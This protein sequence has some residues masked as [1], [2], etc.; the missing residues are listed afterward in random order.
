MMVL[1]REKLVKLD[2]L[3]CEECEEELEFSIDDFGFLVV[4]P[5]QSCIDAYVD[6]AIEESYGSGYEDGREEGYS[7]GSVKGYD[8]GYQDGYE[9][10]R[11]IGYEDGY[12]DRKEE[13]SQ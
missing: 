11:D 8:E 4:R 1:I 2:A 7:D 6:S 3:Y 10:G 13:E 12:S 9:T 5:C